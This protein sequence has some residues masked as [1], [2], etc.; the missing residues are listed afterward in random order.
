MKS[1]LRIVAGASLLLPLLWACKTEKPD[2]PDIE[3]DAPVL[4]GEFNGEHIVLE[5]EPILNALSF[6]IEG[7]EA[8]AVEYHAIGAPTY[9]PFNVPDTEVEFGHSYNFRI[10]AVSGEV[11]SEWS[12]VV[13]VAVTRNL[14]LPVI[15]CN[16]SFTSIEVEWEAVEGATSYKVEHKTTIGS[17]WTADYTGNGDDVSY[18]VK[19]EGLESGISYDV[20]VAAVADGYADTYCAPVTVA[21][22][23][24]PAAIITTADQL[25]AWLQ[26]ISEETTDVAILD[27]DI[28]MS[29]KTITSASGFGGTFDGQGHII[30]NLTSSV[31]MFE[32][33][34]GAL[35]NI[36]FDPSCSFTTGSNIFGAFVAEDERGTYEAIK[37]KGPVTFTATGDVSGDLIIGGLIGKTVGATLTGCSNSGPVTIN[38]AGHS[39]KAAG[40]GG[41]VG[42][43]ESTTFDTCTNRGAI[44][45]NA[46]YGDPRNTLNGWS[47]AGIA[48][49]GIM[50]NGYDHGVDKY[51]T[52]KS[53]QNETA[54]VI[55][56][57]H[58]RLDGLTP[59]GSTSNKGGFVC[60]GGILGKA[61]GNAKSCK[62]FAPINVTA[63][64]SD[65]SL[66]NY[67]NYVVYVGG[68]A[69]CGRYAISL[70]SCRNDGDITVDYD[71]KF[72]GNR[73]RSAIG[74]I[75]GWQDYAGDEAVKGEAELFAHYCNQRGKITVRAGAAAVGGIFGFS[76]EQVGNKVYDSCTIDYSGVQGHVGGLVGNVGDNPTYY[77]IKGCSCA[78][79]IVAEDTNQ[80]DQ[81]FSVGGFIGCWGRNSSNI[82]NWKSLTHTG[83]DENGTPCS[84]TGSVSSTTVSRVGIAVGFIAAT[85]SNQNLTFGHSVQK[86]KASGTFGKKD[87]EITSID[88][89]NVETYAIGGNAGA[90]V[91]V[92]IEYAND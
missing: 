68:V 6:K 19:I 80:D 42:S 20:R 24:A 64:T 47:N 53:C 58:T 31:P 56:L 5:W 70:D 2:L 26:S 27:A 74:G 78:A 75:C 37:N 43:A 17:E 45:L 89:E 30:R 88:S 54:G 90:T 82:E 65:R 36:T 87:V 1:F 14:P 59:D 49:G 66:G 40:L 73:D 32:K 52:F 41:L 34:S 39:H 4:L 51:C 69:G 83:T 28:D 46:D 9:S 8:T 55:T 21:T 44:T 72:H 61:R 11:E 13:T 3:L 85:N 62:N 33:N 16:P 91:T 25:I 60:V 18:K 79:T 92:H 57:N 81:Y 10:K 23:A 67:R 15:T 48:I 63:T 86:I 29:G 71:G 77:P 22:I 50:G 7:K 38:A 12:N 35:C 84:F 76:G